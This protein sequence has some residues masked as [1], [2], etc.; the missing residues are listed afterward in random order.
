MA[1]LATLQ[2]L[3]QSFQV[4]DM[5]WGE[6]YELQNNIGSQ[7][8]QF[9]LR[10]DNAHVTDKRKFAEETKL[11]ADSCLMNLRKP[12]EEVERRVRPYISHLKKT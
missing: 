7:I 2:R 4:A 12:I 6:M 9:H 8:S 5:C 3:S 11:H 1:L 10:M